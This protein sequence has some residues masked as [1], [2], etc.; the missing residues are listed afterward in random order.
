MLLTRE[1][2]L[3]GQSSERFIIFS[4][5]KYQ[6]IAWLL[7]QG[8]GKENVYLEQIISIPVVDHSLL[9]VN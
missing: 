5:S 7:F 2:S 8:N 6:N 3:Y 9:T 1:L 4:K